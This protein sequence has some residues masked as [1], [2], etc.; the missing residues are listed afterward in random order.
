MHQFAKPVKYF[1]RYI[2]NFSNTKRYL[3]IDISTV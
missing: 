1:K 2:S 3:T